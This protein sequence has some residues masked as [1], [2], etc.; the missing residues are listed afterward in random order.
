MRK[1]RNTSAIGFAILGYVLGALAAYGVK[2]ILPGSWN[3]T[4]V[5]LIGYGIIILIGGAFTF[6]SGRF[7]GGR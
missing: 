6:L 1:R 4:T 7:K 3:P 5:N 2:K